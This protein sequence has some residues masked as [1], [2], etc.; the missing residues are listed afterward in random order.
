MVL[1]LWCGYA[2]HVERMGGSGSFICRYY[3][4]NIVYYTMMWICTC[5]WGM[6]G[7]I[8]QTESTREQLVWHYTLKHA[9]TYIASIQ[10][11]QPCAA[12]W[13]SDM[14]TWTF[15]KS[16]HTTQ[17]IFVLVHYHMSI[18]SLFFFL[19]CWPA[20]GWSCWAVFLSP[21]ALVVRCKAMKQAFL[22]WAKLVCVGM[23]G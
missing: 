3:S 12:A 5:G 16:R 2:P 18:F 7:S 13:H 19:L 23:C 17:V 1:A 21:W 8:W 22:L 15:W 9:G 6:N 10:V 11:G 14:N 20:A 4:V